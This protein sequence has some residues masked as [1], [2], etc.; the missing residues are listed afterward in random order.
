[1]ATGGFSEYSIRM[2]TEAWI[3]VATIL[4]DTH[5]S[6][7]IIEKVNTISN[8]YSTNFNQTIVTNLFAEFKTMFNSLDSHT[9]T[10]IKNKSQHII[11]TNHLHNITLPDNFCQL[12]KLQ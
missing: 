4:R 2:Y 3:S 9:R 7:N 8:C 1:M 6:E 10:Q 11:N 5:V 12:L